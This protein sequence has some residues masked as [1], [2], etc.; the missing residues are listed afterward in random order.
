MHFNVKYFRR[1]KREGIESIGNKHVIN[2]F[3]YN[4][5]YK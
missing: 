4:I 3:I 2:I 5:F 1:F